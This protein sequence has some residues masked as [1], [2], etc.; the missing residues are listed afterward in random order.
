M[1]EKV[2]FRE[3]IANFQGEYIVPLPCLAN[4]NIFP[5]EVFMPLG[6]K[7]VQTEFN[8]Q[9]ILVSQVHYMPE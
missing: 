3:E 9:F 6:D 2:H 8:W 1:K 7:L 4:L 5:K